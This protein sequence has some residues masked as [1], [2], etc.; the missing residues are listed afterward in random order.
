MWTSSH[1]SHWHSHCIVTLWLDTG[2]FTLSNPR[3]WPE[4]STVFSSHWQ[5]FSQAFQ[6]VCKHLLAMLPLAL[7]ALLS[8][9][10]PG[11]LPVASLM[12][13]SEPCLKHCSRLCFKINSVSTK[14]LWDRANVSCNYCINYLD[15]EYYG[16]VQP[17]W[18]RWP[19][20]K[21][22]L[23]LEGNTSKFRSSG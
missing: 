10:V 3:K 23:K 2:T 11:D 13:H 22:F 7:L 4:N 6:E 20:E 5:E 17:L 21:L 1:Y 15:T 12:M 14:N 16:A 18:N 8:L 19:P 9:I